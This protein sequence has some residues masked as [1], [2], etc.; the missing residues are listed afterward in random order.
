MEREEQRRASEKIGLGWS[1][2]SKENQR[3]AERVYKREVK[4][5]YWIGSDYIK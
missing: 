2:Q 4:I 3:R 5:F 1:E